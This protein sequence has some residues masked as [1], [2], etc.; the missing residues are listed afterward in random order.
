MLSVNE[1]PHLLKVLTFFDLLVYGLAYVSPVGPW[2]T[3]AFTSSLAGGAV[4]L[5][6]LLGAFALSFTAMSYA[7][8]ATAVPGVG[9]AYSY[10]RYSMGE[11]VG[12]LT[13]WMLLLDYLLMPALMY[14][15][16]GITFAE[17]AP[18][19]PAWGWILLIAA[20]NIGVNWCGVK[21]S[22]HF[23]TATLLL[24]FAMLFI[25]LI[26]A[27]YTMSKLNMPTFTAHAWWTTGKTTPTG[28]FAGASL[29]VL[30][31]LG[32]DAITT[33]SSEV[34]V[35][36]RRLIGRAILATLI[37]LGLL[38]IIDVWVLDDLA[39]GLTFKDPTTATFET[40]GTRI[41]PVLGAAAAWGGAIVVA[42]SITPPM[43]T[44][45]SRVLYSMA[46][47]GEMPAMLAKLHPRYG[48]PHV[49]VLASGA[50]SITVALYFASQFDTLTSMVNFGAITAFIAV[51]ASVI[52]LFRI[53]RR[54]G[55]LFGTVVC[56]IIGIA[57]LGAVLTQM[58]PLG[59][60][61]GVCWTVAG[62]VVYCIV[63]RQKQPDGDARVSL[64]E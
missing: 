62:I 12:F 46:T 2:S 19:L 8:M 56:P 20:Y 52:A 7:K 59:L 64:G 21:T 53:K 42:I 9:S 32:F 60:A 50:I 17:Y 35:E 26:A 25:F 40:I 36:Q 22:A 33:L 10:A 51:N 6:F 18:I 44:A 63:R 24:Q 47:H 15:F 55:S 31:Y 34:R 57:T 13:G 28:V 43:V 37:V 23:N 30:A 38:A 61:V 16:C 41:N 54:T 4:A 3:W 5:A 11:S 14:V 49:A 1:T 45:V 48:V 27:I 39:R 29:C 58:S